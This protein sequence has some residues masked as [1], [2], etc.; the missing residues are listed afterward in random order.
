RPLRDRF[1]RRER[2]ARCERP[3]RRRHRSGRHLLHVLG[4][5]Q[6]DLV[7]RA[8]I[9]AGQLQITAHLNLPNWTHRMKNTPKSG[10]TLLELLVVLVIISILSTIAVGVY[11]KEVLRAKVARTRAEIRTLEVAINRYQID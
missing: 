6:R 8:V 4:A 5:V 10:V 7:Q 3:W 1:L 9:D 2:A 11:T